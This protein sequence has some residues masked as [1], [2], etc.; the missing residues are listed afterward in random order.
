MVIFNSYVSLPEGNPNWLIIKNINI[1]QRGSYTTNEVIM[2]H[3]K[4][5]MNRS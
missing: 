4:M 1:F 5:A 2:F 3:I